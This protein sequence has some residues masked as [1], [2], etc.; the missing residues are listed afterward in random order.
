MIRAHGQTITLAGGTLTVYRD[1][2]T[3]ALYGP[4]R[5]IEVAT[6]TG[7]TTHTCP[8]PLRQ[9]LVIDGPTPPLAIDFGPGQRDQLEALAGELDRIIGGDAPSVAAQ[10]IPGFCVTVIGADAPDGVWDKPTAIAVASVT[11]GNLGAVHRYS[12]SGDPARDT[13]TFTS[14]A[15][16]LSTLLEKQQ[17][18]TASTTGTGKAVLVAHNAYKVLSILRRTAARLGVAVPA[19]EVMCTLALWRSLHH[20]TGWASEIQ[21]AAAMSGT[22]T[23]DDPQ[24]VDETCPLADRLAATVRLA[25]ALAVGTG[26]PVSDIRALAAAAG[27]APGQ[28]T[29][30]ALTPVLEEADAAIAYPAPAAGTATPKKTSTAAAAAPP[31]ASG[32]SGGGRGSRRGP[33]PW[34]RVQAPETIPDPNPD[35]DPEGVLF[36]QLVVLSGDFGAHSKEELFRLIAD[37]GAQLKTNVTKKTTILVAGDWGKKTSKVKKAERYKQDGQDIRIWRDTDLYEA[38]GI[39]ADPMQEEPPF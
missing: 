3:R 37:K 12:F 21:A 31:A 20:S 39:A 14:L 11:D 8:G 30:G 10:S 25:C 1:E 29:G 9:K 23:G 28:V 18:A 16:T 19:A 15:D 4:G 22:P 26:Q 27:L 13:Q 38:L 34:S 32:R 7:Y 2:L 36:G 17:A 5:V 24:P 33:A 35:A 6:I